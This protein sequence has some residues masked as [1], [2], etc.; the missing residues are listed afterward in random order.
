VTKSVGDVLKLVSDQGVEMIDFR[1]IDLPGL[2]QHFSVPP[3]QLTEESFEE[4]FGFD[5]SSIRGFQEIQESDM[6]L[7]PDASTAVMD[8][9]TQHKTLIIN[10]FVGDPVT[11]EAYSRDPRGIARKAE[12]YLTSTGIADTAY[13][14]PE[15]EFYIF[16]SIR[17]DQNQY[18]GYYYVDAI[19]GAW[20]SGAEEGGRNLGFKPRYKEGYFPVPPTDHYQDLR[21]EMVMTMIKAGLDIEVHH[22]E[23]GTAGQAEIDMR[24]DTM[25]N[26]ADKVMM[27]KYIV[28][29]VARRYGKTATF[30]P[31]PIFEDNG[32]GMHTHQSLWTN[33]EPLFYDEAGWAGVSELGRH[34]IGG[35]LKHAPAILAFAAPTTNSYR[36]L[37]PGY[38]APV[39]LVMSQ[40]NRS[41]A[42]RIPVYSKSPKAKRVEFRCPDPSC[43]PY[44]AF[45]AMLMAG[46]DGIRNKIEPPEPVDKNI[47][48]LPPAEAANIA[49]VPG[50]LD[51]S[52]A[53][54]AEDHAFLLEGDVFT[55]DVVDTWIEYKTEAELDAVRLR[56]HPWE[57]QLY[58]D[59]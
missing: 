8:P 20:N 1:F 22:H 32:S 30:M 44:L 25:L 39:N 18:S 53:A 24:F 35:L 56:P 55:Q 36:R 4:G 43:N 38:E 59:I 49:K 34:Y 33:G 46:L 31:K 51:E 47:Y 27:Y 57:F 17:F 5:G 29:N 11:G 37:V 14:G 40:R 3:T 23:V 16:D 42:A 26:M 10:C 41:A 9:F 15:A 7:F 12:A 21:S 58:Y 2:S 48:D 52:L 50:S 13:F 45:S 19:E 54:L 28:K 6:L